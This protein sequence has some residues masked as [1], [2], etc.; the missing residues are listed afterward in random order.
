MRAAGADPDMGRK[1]FI[2]EAGCPI[3]AGFPALRIDA[4]ARLA[5]P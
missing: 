5:A 1:I 2:R 4:M 3:A